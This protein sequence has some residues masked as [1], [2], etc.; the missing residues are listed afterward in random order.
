MEVRTHTR[1]TCQ[2]ILDFSQDLDLV[3]LDNIVAAMYTGAGAD[4]RMAQQVLAQFQEHPD[5]WQRVPVIMQQS[6]NSQT[7]YIALQILDKLIATR[8]KVLPVDQQQG[9]RNFIVELIVV[10]SSEESNLRSERTLLGKLD[11][12]L[13]QILKQ[14][15]PH[16]WPNFIPEIVSSSRG[17]LAI[18]ENNM[19][20]LRLLSEEV[21]DFSAE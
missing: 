9:I 21:F 15:W 4:Q 5:A 11:T 17:S 6:T 8:W 20:I 2:S 13:I 16:N 7:K 1:L 10:M 12:T 14:E 18:C 19:A 3:L